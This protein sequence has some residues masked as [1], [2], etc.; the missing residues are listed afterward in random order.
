MQVH[1]DGIGFDTAAV[2][3]QSGGLGLKGMQ[4]R[5]TRLGGT[6]TVTSTPNEGTWVRVE[7]DG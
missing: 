5:V 3:E 4:E 6:L 2:G 1:D 7:V